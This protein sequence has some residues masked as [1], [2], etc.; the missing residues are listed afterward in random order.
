LVLIPILSFFLLKDADSFRRSALAMLPRGRLRWRGDEFFEDINSTLAAYIRAQLTACVVIGA[1]CSLGFALIGFPSPLVLG[2]LAGM[3]EFVPLVGPLSVAIL[4]VLLALLQSG[5]GMA[6]VV[7]LFLG[8]LRVVQDY[9][10]YPRIIGHGIHLHP[11]AVILAILAGAE[12][13]GVAGIF[14]AIPAIAILTV[15]YRH[16]LEHRGSETIAEVIEEAVVESEVKSETITTRPSVAT[17][18]DE[19]ARVRPDLLTGELKPPQ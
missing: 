4:L 3:L 13:A 12:I 2:V 14:L 19:M 9:V 18:A 11:L 7:L 10:I 6:L 8:V 1:I 15:S 5:L 16:W 17:T